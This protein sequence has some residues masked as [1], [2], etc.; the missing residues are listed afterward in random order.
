MGAP[1]CENYLTILLMKNL[2][3]F[4]IANVIKTLTISTISGKNACT[5]PVTYDLYITN[6]SPLII[7]NRIV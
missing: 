4:A 3:E 6:K 5:A 2:S 1:I 7:I